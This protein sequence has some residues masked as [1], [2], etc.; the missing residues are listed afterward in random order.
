MNTNV[1]YS[2]FGDAR[3]ARVSTYTREVWYI[4]METIKAS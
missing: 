2:G 3:I 4:F 1:I